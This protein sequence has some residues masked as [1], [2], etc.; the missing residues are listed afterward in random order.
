MSIVSVLSGVSDRLLSPAHHLAIRNA[1]FSARKK[2]SPLLRLVYGTFDAATL[3]R[4]LESRLDADFDC[5]MVH[6]SI[7]K[8]APM[9]TEGPLELVRALTAFVG[10]E[11]SLAMPA[12][13]FGDP[14][15]GGLIDTLTARPEL[16]L[17]R[18][19]SQVGIATELFRRTPGV[20]CSRHPIYRVCAI[21]PLAQ[22]LT[23]GHERASSN[24]GPG[25]PFDVMA[26]SR[27]WI[28]GI[29]KPIEILT[30]VHHAEDVLGDAFP[31]PRGTQR[32]FL[33]VQLK[34]GQETF[35]YRL[36]G[37]TPSW[38]R[39]MWRLRDLMPEGQL[40]EWTFHGAPL[41]AVRAA[42]VTAAL[43]AAA[44]RG[45]TLYEPPEGR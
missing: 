8:L 25:T 39:N 10:P 44:A 32:N 9:Y 33:E 38:R 40:Q 7:N 13:Y 36:P 43:V 6:S 28:V 30:Q 3:C 41:F 45:E 34:D 29:G 11:R 42:D 24:C 18:T 16:D 15:I 31:V 5:L 20:R 23:E 2:A 17:R 37:G 14:R 22:R 1:Y 12:F 35:P 27:T 21:G 4:H 19:P 26:Q